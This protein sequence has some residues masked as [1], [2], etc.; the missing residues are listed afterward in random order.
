MSVSKHLEY[1]RTDVDRLR[2]WD[3]AV[4]IMRTMSTL[5]IAKTWIEFSNMKDTT[6]PIDLQVLLSQRK[7]LL[8]A[9]LFESNSSGVAVCDSSGGSNNLI[10]NT[11]KKCIPLCEEL[12]LA[13]T[14]I[15][16]YKIYHK[17]NL[18]PAPQKYNADPIITDSA[19][20][21][22]HN[23]PSSTPVPPADPRLDQILSL[24]HT[25]STACAGLAAKVVGMETHLASMDAKLTAIIERLGAVQ[26]SVAQ[27]GDDVIQAIHNDRET[28]IDA[29]E[30]HLTDL[31]R[32]ARDDIPRP[33]IAEP[34]PDVPRLSRPAA[35][36]HKPAGRASGPV[37][38]SVS[39]PRVW[40][41]PGPV[42]YRR[43]DNS[44]L[45]EPMDDF[46]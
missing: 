45:G 34:R 32:G 10:E 5:D 36:G 4:E 35:T 7:I 46:C 25:H 26:I 44:L 6:G 1:V 20:T 21:S 31:V 24:L 33:D 17:I 16:D 18:G 2:S 38:R 28:K 29:L 37:A 12:K 40:N 43:K 9:A 15:D 39:P 8:H 3:R 27:T 42:D 23:T 30:K 11:L 41:P 22:S 13:F 14:I 19:K